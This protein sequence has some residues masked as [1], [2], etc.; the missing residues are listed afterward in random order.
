MN[1]EAV[2]SAA[3]HACLAIGERPSVRTVC[4]M[5]RK[6]SGRG[7]RLEDVRLWLLASRDTL[8]IQPEYAD[9]SLRD[10]P[11]VLKSA[12]SDT[13]ATLPGIHPGNLHAG[14][15][16]LETLA[17]TRAKALATKVSKNGTTETIAA[18]LTP[19]EPVPFPGK[20]P[21][22]PL[23]GE[24]KKLRQIAR[25]ALDAFGNCKTEK[26][27]ERNLT[28]YTDA[29]AVFRSRGVT[30]GAMWQAFNDCRLARE[31][32]PLFGAQAKQALAY[33]PARQTN[34]NGAPGPRGVREV[35]SDELRNLG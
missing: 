3:H 13:P 21:N 7:I 4:A 30:A 9:E 8:G 25:I 23:P 14:A 33:L 10:T 12:V 28:A 19:W 1:R 6:I 17:S 29:L 15:R 16:Q 32:K 5:F 2:L 20:K 11:P 22:E 18:I 31:G 26:A 24:P 35:T 34:G 27:I